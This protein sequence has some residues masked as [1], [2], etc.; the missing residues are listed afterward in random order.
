MWLFPSISQQN[1]CL[2]S[3]E[4]VFIFDE[5]LHHLRLVADVVECRH[6]VQVGGTQESGPKNDAQVLRIHQVVLLI[7]RYP[8]EEAHQG[9]AINNLSIQ[10]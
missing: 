2:F 8:V 9:E 1:G 4:D 6:G 5:E 10:L 7:Q 3:E